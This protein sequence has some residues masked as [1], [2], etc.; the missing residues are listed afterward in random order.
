MEILQ[1]KCYISPYTKF[2]FNDDD[3][4]ITHIGNGK[5]IKVK[6][7]VL[8][9][10]KDNIDK[11]KS[12]QD[13]I[14]QGNDAYSKEYISSLLKEF[15]KNQM[16][17]LDEEFRNDTA[18][19]VKEIYIDLTNRCNLRCL[20]CATCAGEYIKGELSFEEICKIIDTCCELKPEKLIL[21]GGEIF[22]R[23]DVEEII[24]Y[25]SNKFNGVLCIMSN[26][27]LIDENRIKL[28]CEYVDEVSLSLDGYNEETTDYI[29]GTGV[30]NKVIEVIDK[31]QKASVN[32]ISLS[33]VETKLTENH[34]NDFNDLC[35][36]LKV[37]AMVR[38]FEPIGRGESNYD[39]LK[40]STKSYDKD[41]IL[42]EEEIKSIKKN[43]NGKS[44]CNAGKKVLA[45]DHIGDVYPCEV[46]QE[47]EYKLG[48]IL[49]DGAK[50]NYD[51]PIQKLKNC[52]VDKIE[53]CKECNIRY[54]CSSGCPK[55]DITRYY[56]ED[57]KTKHCL[58]INDI[59]TK[60]IW[61]SN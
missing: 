18:E 20:H 11:S 1:S 55:S 51:S 27:V 30:F 48:N 6:S 46:L 53:G 47:D 54:F 25:A 31:L 9:F 49:S 34:V 26:G 13:I 8:S 15:V 29:R 3:A 38:K 19:E 60:I 40:T 43:I 23:K 57:Y 45:I 39:V 7:D 17:D 14:N 16:I 28:I 52:I 4:I 41:E 56:N 42:T 24:K 58:R 33:M 44:L 12:I 2:I 32:K 61:Q 37:K 22:V 10:I 35:K 59:Y 50:L 21:T 36:K 5:W